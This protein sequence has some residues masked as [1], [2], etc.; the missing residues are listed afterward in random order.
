MARSAPTCIRR[1]LARAALAAACLLAIAVPP[2]LATDATPP[3][4]SFVG[5][6]A[7]GPYAHASLSTASEV[8][9]NPLYSGSATARVAA[10]DPQSGIAFVT[11]SDGPTGWS[12]GG[13]TP[14]DVGGG[15]YEWTYT[16][17]A[18]AAAGSLQ[19]IASHTDPSPANKVQSAPVPF[20]V[21]SDTTPPVASSTTVTIG[22]PGWS[23]VTGDTLTFPAAASFTDAGSSASGVG[24]ITRIVQRRDGA[25]DGA[26]GCNASAGSWTNLTTVAPGITSISIDASSEGVCHEYQLRVEDEVGNFIELPA[27]AGQFHGLDTTPPTIA[28]ASFSTGANSQY[29][30]LAAADTIYV[31]GNASGDFTV[32]AVPTD[33]TSSIAALRFEALT[34][35]WTPSADVDV[36]APGPWTQTY[37]WSPGAAEP[38]SLRIQVTDAAGNAAWVNATHTILLD[39]GGIGAGSATLDFTSPQWVSSTSVSTTMTGTMVDDLTGIA[40]Y[41]LQREEA[42]WS[43]GAG[44]SCGAFTGSYTNVGT[45]IYGSPPPSLGTIVDVGRADATCYRYR[46]EATDA[47]GNIDYLA[48]GGEVMVDLTNPSGTFDPMPNYSTTSVSVSGTVTDAMSGFA[49]GSAGVVVRLEDLSSPGPTTTLFTDPTVAGGTFG[50]YSWDVSALSGSYRL[51]LDVT[52]QAGNTATGVATADVIVDP[53]AP[54]ITFDG[55]AEGTGTS[56]QH[57]D[58]GNDMVAWVRTSSPCSGSIIAR[59]LP[60]DPESGIDHVTAAG[61]TATGWTPTSDATVSASPWQQAYSWVAGS[62]DFGSGSATATNGAGADSSAAAFGILTDNDAPTGGDVSY[63]LG[64]TTTAPLTI[65]VTDFA[66]VAGGSGIYQQQL[67][68]DEVTRTAADCGAGESWPGTWSTVVAQT[69]AGAPSQSLGGSVD[70]TTIATGKCYRYKLVA[71]DNVGN[72]GSSSNTPPAA[73]TDLLAPIG[74]ID[75]LSPTSPLAGTETISGTSSDGSAP[76]ASGVASVTV[77]WENLGDSS[78]GTVGTTATA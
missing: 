62:S 26:G 21:V 73:K 50:S 14:T 3:N 41:H 47:V 17:N 54:T 77:R 45:T 37:T 76:P 22:T 68:R 49:G 1:R 18:A 19:A 74:A 69:V 71:V 13:N 12:F 11:F 36:L 59:F 78:T 5:W 66:D 63:P 58:P 39:N 6:N 35:G 25:T 56:C 67:L 20:S 38:G 30:Y 33:S 32:T 61:A 53:S 29:Q 7:T 42:A 60:D 43:G 15:I 40:S 72:A 24:S 64:W 10:D 34:G 2:A 44:G 4:A 46:V 23:N 9:F 57:V 70:D 27:T 28:S 48:P 8:W 75:T 65:S 31:N 16:W 55:F 51:H 52:D